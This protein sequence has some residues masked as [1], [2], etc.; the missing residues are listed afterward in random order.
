MRTICNQIPGG[1]FLW[2]EQDGAMSTFR[3]GRKR[4]SLS[5]INFF[6][7]KN[8]YIST[9]YLVRVWKDSIDSVSVFLGMLSLVS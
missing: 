8:V 3:C 5:D 2:A 9:Y 7:T 4:S 6:V 1:I